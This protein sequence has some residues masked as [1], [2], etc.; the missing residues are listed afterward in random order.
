[1]PISRKQVRQG[2][3][4]DEYEIYCSSL[5]LKLPKLPVPVLRLCILRARQLILKRG[6]GP[7]KPLNA[8][9]SPRMRDLLSGALSRFEGRLKVL[10]QEQRRQ[11]AGAPK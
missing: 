10:A 5:R 9:R 1:M 3:S 11:G 8:R 4:P 2:C 7:R 6:R